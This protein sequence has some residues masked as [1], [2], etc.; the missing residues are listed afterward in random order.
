[1][2]AQPVAVSTPTGDNE[3]EQDVD[4]ASESAQSG[5]PSSE[6]VEP[7][8]DAG[9]ESAQSRG[10]SAE[11]ID[12]DADVGSELAQSGRQSSEPNNTDADA[13]TES[14][15]S[16]EPSSEP[17]DQD[18][19]AG[20]ESAQAGTQSSEPVDQEADAAT[21]SA[22][23]GGQLSKPEDAYAD[24]VTPTEAAQSRN[25]SET[26]DDNTDSNNS[27]LFRPSDTQLPAGNDSEK[28]AMDA[29]TK[30]DELRAEKETMQQA[31]SGELSRSKEHVEDAH[32]G[33]SF[34]SKLF[35][36]LW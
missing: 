9:A 34:F 32:G 7:D 1:M 30:R 26:L 29:I 11:P 27:V 28:E 13:V 31:Q 33:K 22:Q 36:V 10:P 8:A 5:V 12:Q 21:Q 35:S 17:V 24:G 2:L 23:S 20:T 4:A 14:T 25:P 15:Q 19:N 3:G 6:P 18:T 16:V